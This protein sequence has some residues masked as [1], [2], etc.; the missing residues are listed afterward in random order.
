MAC[1]L[2]DLLEIAA[3]RLQLRCRANVALEQYDGTNT[4]VAYQGADIVVER[5]AMKANG[6]QLR[7]RVKSIVRL[8]EWAAY[9]TN[10]LT[11]FFHD[12]LLLILA[13]PRE[14]QSIFSNKMILSCFQPQYIRGS[15][16]VD[17]VGFGHVTCC[18]TPT[19]RGE[20]VCGLGPI[21]RVSGAVSQSATF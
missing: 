8:V 21:F 13:D 5:W 7:E 4:V 9:L 12:V 11:L 16:G 19:E 18:V 14:S 10:F 20:G 17:V 2:S 6:E 15:R 3:E 1:I